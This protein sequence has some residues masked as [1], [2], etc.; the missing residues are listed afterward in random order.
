MNWRIRRL[1]IRLMETNALTETLR[2]ALI[3]RKPYMGKP[4]PS[5][6]QALRV[7]WWHTLANRAWDRHLRALSAHSRWGALSREAAKEVYK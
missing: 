5:F 1:G 3:M 4:V 2:F 7:A 6:L